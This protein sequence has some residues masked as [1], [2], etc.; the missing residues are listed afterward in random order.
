MRKKIIL[1]LPMIFTLTGCSNSA[2][3]N[4]DI[5]NYVPYAEIPEDYTAEAALEDGCVVFESRSSALWLEDY[6]ENILQR[7]SLVG[8]EEAWEEFL[9]QSGHGDEAKLRLVYYFLEKSD[10]DG[11]L[12]VTDRRIFDLSYKDEKYTLYYE[13]SGEER[14]LEY[15]A[16]KCFEGDYHEQEWFLLGEYYSDMAYNDILNANPLSS[17]GFIIDD[18]AAGEP[19]WQIIYFTDNKNDTD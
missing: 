12:Q 2:E 15:A 19:T 14:S 11:E 9:S 1:L 8:G 18:A 6:A 13:D 7:S 17:Q 16:L 3:P 5:P 4:T 10:D